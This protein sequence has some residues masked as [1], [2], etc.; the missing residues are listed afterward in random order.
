[1]IIHDNRRGDI[2]RLALRGDRGAVEPIRR[3]VRIDA[4]FGRQVDARVAQ[5]IEL[6]QVVEG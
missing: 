2:I 3:R 1:M 5:I 4:F 6:V